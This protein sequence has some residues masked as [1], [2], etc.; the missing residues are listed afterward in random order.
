MC[1]HTPDT[2]TVPGTQLEDER[3]PSI[4]QPP[5]FGHQARP[6]QGL[7]WGGT[8]LHTDLENWFLIL[9]NEG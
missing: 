8:S 4:C 6:G 1:K 7:S 9:K 5:G 2:D 3:R